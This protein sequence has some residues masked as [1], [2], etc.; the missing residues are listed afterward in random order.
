VQ[1]GVFVN[2]GNDGEH[3]AR[4]AALVV[5]PGLTEA[6]IL[7]E[8]RRSVDPVFLPRPLVKVDRLPRTEA[9][10]LPRTALLELLRQR[11]SQ[12]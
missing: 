11:G 2:P 9:G 7:T 8:L 4:L 10:K 6:E 1:D 5:A 3:I 12:R